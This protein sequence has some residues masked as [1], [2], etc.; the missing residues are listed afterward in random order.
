MS[1]HPLSQWQLPSGVPRGA[2]DYAQSAQ[3]AGEYDEYF[4]AN[5]L[6]EFD[7][8]VILTHFRRPGR[9]VDLGAGT[10]RAV[11]ALARRGFTG[12]AVDLSPHMLRIVAEKARRERLPVFSVLGNIAELDF[13]ADRSLDYALCLFS[14][15][16][17]IRG[18]ENRL[19]VLR[20]VRRILK[21]GGLFVLH[22]HNYWFNL[23]DPLG[24]R[25]LRTHWRQRWSNRQLER[26]DKFFPFHDIPQMFLHTFTQGEV[27]RALRASGFRILQWIPLSVGRQSP[28]PC[29]WFLGRFRA[30]G[31]IVVCE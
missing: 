10:G 12:L 21:P 14:T 31:W 2:W 28:L 9:V 17:M 16:G 25:W 15:L 29:S 7:E 22:V 23:F 1:N 26:G 3:I 5:R 13:L 11:V 4:A 8:Q 27:R 20:H 19:Q 18:R 6:F 24:R 30:N